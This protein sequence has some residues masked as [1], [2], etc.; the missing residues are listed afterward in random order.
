MVCSLEFAFFEPVILKILD[1]LEG[2]VFS[3]DAKIDLYTFSSHNMISKPIKL[4][5]ILA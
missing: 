1:K 2:L 4:T 5:G 3:G